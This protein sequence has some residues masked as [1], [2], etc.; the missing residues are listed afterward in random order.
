M[1]LS[2][3]G[4]G[5]LGLFHNGVL[6]AFHRY[7]PQVL[8]E[9]IIGTS[10]GSLAAAAACCGVCSD[11]AMLE[12]M[13]MTVTARA[14]KPWAFHPRYSFSNAVRAAVE[15]VLP[16]N[17][18]EICSGRL[19]VGIT[20]LRDGKHRLVS[21]F[22]TREQLIEALVCSCFIPLLSGLKPP[23][24]KEAYYWDGGLTQICPILNNETIRVCPFVAAVD[25]C[26]KEEEIMSSKDLSWID[27]LM[28]NAYVVKAGV[29]MRFSYAHFLRFL[30]GFVPPNIESYCNLYES[31]FKAALHFIRSKGL[32]QPDETQAIVQMGKTSD[33]LR[34]LATPFGIDP[35]KYEP[36]TAKDYATIAIKA[37]GLPALVLWQLNPFSKKVM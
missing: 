17:A 16:Q 12:L 23:R 31:G 4:G 37:F 6:D 26:P 18:H 5:F 3:S 33:N 21:H 24:Y 11:R 29:K 13:E 9:K 7:A 20:K 15:R 36:W 30:Q 22:D 35:G 14:A 2:L 28:Q 10:A 8:E 34:L 19:H 32:A 27:R 1:H 25:I